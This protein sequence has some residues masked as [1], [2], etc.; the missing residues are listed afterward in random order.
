MTKSTEPNE[1]LYNEGT[2]VIVGA[3]EIVIA[4]V[5]Y[6]S[7]TLHEINTYTDS[8]GPIIFS[9]VTEVKNAYANALKRG[10][11]IRLITEI[12]KDNLSHTKERLGYVSELR[13]M[14]G[15]SGTFAITDKHYL[16]NI[17]AENIG[18]F[19]CIHSNVSS[20]VEQQ[21]HIFENLWNNAIPA[22]EK[23]RLL[24]ESDNEEFSKIL[25]NP[26]ETQNLFL[27]LVKSSREEILVLFSITDLLLECIDSGFLERLAEA[28][29]KRKVQ[30][31]IL[32]PADIQTYSNM[33]IKTRLKAKVNDNI[34]LQKDKIKEGVAARKGDILIKT[35]DK[36]FK[37]HYLSKTSFILIVDSKVSMLGAMDIDTRKTKEEA[38][39]KD[40]EPTVADNQTVY[41]SY[42]NNEGGVLS[43]ISIFETLWENAMDI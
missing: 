23:I 11:K 36:D 7:E 10:V 18:S 8:M 24:D 2:E 13:H 43:N 37:S 19:Q 28:I 1:K 34:Q 41:C 35:L 42:T 39:L 5:K 9:K 12:T 25:H 40:L 27:D 32:L 6:L 21:K 31:R 26:K 14:D 30:F 29:G 20:F 15:I 4:N 17:V 16:S 38:T 22:I 33:N 3:E